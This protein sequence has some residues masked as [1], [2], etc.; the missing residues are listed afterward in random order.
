MGKGFIFSTNGQDGKGAKFNKPLREKL[1][2]K[3]ATIAGEFNCPALDTYGL[4]KITGGLN[5]GR[6]NE[7]DLK[8]AE[9]FAQTLK[10]I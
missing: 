3:G 9:T 4:L 7:E 6:P 2:T 10:S 5:K 1:Q 8:N